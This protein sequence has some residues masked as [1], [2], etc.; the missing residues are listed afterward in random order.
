MAR[1][2]TIKPEFWR[3]EGLSL[4]SSEAA[5]LAIGILNHSDD[6]GYFNANPKLLEADV[7][8]LRDLSR[9]T[10]VLIQELSEIGYLDLFLGTDGKQYGKVKNFERHQV[11]NKPKPSQI[12]DLI[13]KKIEYGSITVAV[14]P[15]KEQGTGKG[16]EQGKEQGGGTSSTSV[17]QPSSEKSQKRKSQNIPYQ[18]IVDLYHD[19]LPAMPRVLVLNDKRK[20]HIKN[21]WNQPEHEL[22]KPQDL[23]WWKEYFEYAA[24]VPFLRGDNQRGWKADFEFLTTFNNLVKVAEGKYQGAN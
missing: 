15:G 4:V 19:L 23:A 1:I 20:S 21:C 3:D 11:I 13:D 12:K 24:T 10:T 18:K 16:K 17:D 6:E 8:P 5:L 14:P 2:R 7:F 9:T 22:V